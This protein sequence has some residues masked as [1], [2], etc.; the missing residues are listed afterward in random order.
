MLWLYLHFPR[1]Q[2][3]TQMP[4]TAHHDDKVSEEAPA[5]VVNERDHRLCQINP[6]AAKQGLRVGMGLATAAVLCRE[7]HLLP[8]RETL[9]RERLEAFSQ[10][11]YRICGDLSLDYPQ[12]I[13]AGITRMIKYHNGLDNYFK[14]I[15]ALMASFQVHWQ[16]GSGPSPLTAKLLARSGRNLV[17]DNLPHLQIECE[18]CPLA[19]TDLPKEAIK[20]LQRLG[21]RTL[22]ELLTIPPGELARR[23]DR[24]VVDYVLRFQ[25]Q[26][27][28]PLPFYQPPDHFRRS[29]ELPHEATMTDRL[30]PWVEQL[31][32]E[33]EQFLLARNQQALRLELQLCFRDG[34]PARLIIGSAKGEVRAV[35]WQHLVDLVLERHPLAAPVVTMTL[36]ALEFTTGTTGSES[37]LTRQSAGTM[38]PA[39]LVSLLEARLGSGRVTTPHHRDDFRPLVA[40]GES[41]AQATV[42][43]E[44]R[45]I[46]SRDAP[47]SAMEP[48]LPSLRPAFLLPKP[49]PCR[50]PL[51]IV[52]GP[53]RIATGWWDPT[54]EIR[55][56][57]VARNGKGQWCWV[58][59]EP[60]SPEWFLQGYFA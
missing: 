60:D 47:L 21:I 39:E 53:E 3:D 17:S 4:V 30:R 35:R 23:F 28:H 6:S 57:Y 55:D 13:W 18:H 37:L 25:G 9:E 33:L 5:A 41:A 40:N 58:F 56:Y 22:G 34:P 15:S 59:R 50:E 10:G 24:P 29:R 1:L 49:V 11:L 27:S 52:E 54:P 19:F 48:P 42:S 43:Q 31:L 46:S 2:L 38:Q 32:K 26:T 51:M 36:S 16:W 20:P 45:V 12:G 7:V 14:K 44:E 8:Y